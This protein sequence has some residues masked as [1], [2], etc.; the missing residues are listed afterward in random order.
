MT[1][2]TNQPS[3]LVYS[4]TLGP[5]IITFCDLVSLLLTFFILIYARQ[6]SSV[7]PNP[8]SIISPSSHSA[9]LL[10]TYAPQSGENLP[11]YQYLFEVLNEQIK[12][13]PELARININKHDTNF[14]L[15]IPFDL[16]FEIEQD[17]FSLKGL[18]ILTFIINSIQLVDR[19]I[20]L[21]AIAST[22]DLGHSGDALHHLTLRRLFLLAHELHQ[23]G[24]APSIA[25]RIKFDDLS[26][27]S[28]SPAASLANSH[29]Q[30]ALADRRVQL[31]IFL[32]HHANYLSIY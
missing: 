28:L 1:D 25:T 15:T 10:E 19:P 29:S 12:K 27:D 16:L 11:H 4:S 31:T 30:V 21:E 8:L 7:A 5:W 18:S 6:H 23:S 9:P 32:P 14:T 26:Y 24:Y 3:N 2:I 17:Q 22:Y 13:A 20:T